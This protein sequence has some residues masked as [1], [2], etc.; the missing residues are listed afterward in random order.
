[1]RFEVSAMK[2]QNE[3]KTTKIGLIPGDWTVVQVGSLGNVRKG[4]GISRNSVQ[5]S[6][7]PC[8]RYG[9]IYT[10]YNY[11]VTKVKSYISDETAST[12]EPI[13]KGDL[14]FTGSGETA[15]DIGKAVVYLLDEP[16]Y[17]GGDLLILQP[18]NLIVDPLYLSYQW[19]TENIR[20]QRRKS[21]QGASI[22]HL[23]ADALI[24]IAVPLPPLPEQQ[25]I[26]DILS[27]VDENISETESL[28]EK[29]RFLKQ[30]M[31]QR[32][33]TQGIGHTEFKDTEVGRI[34]ME[35]EVRSTEELLIDAKGS[36]KIGP[37]G[38]QL[39]KEYLQDSGY[40]RV[41]GQENVFINDFKIGT[42]WLSQE[43]FDKLRS[44]EIHPGE[45]VISMMGTIGKCVVVPEKICPGIMDSHLIRL[46]PDKTKVDTIYLKYVIGESSTIQSQI[47]ALSVGGI[48]DGLSSG[49]IKRLR[50]PIPS[51][52][53]QR[54]IAVIL[55][56]ID[57][58]IET[59]LTK[60]TAL[61]RLKSGLM[62][63]L[64]TGKIRV[65]V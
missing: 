32:L 11:A 1:M 6:G 37:F 59:Y 47:K 63:Q 40:Y 4:K 38:S 26:A 58:Q 24:K 35:W 27:T 65:K 57:D 61:T 14:L 5:D 60:L 36:L 53:E 30:G 16:G 48:M 22:F 46:Q 31:I 20:S 33:L 13:S 15:E 56:T 12:S 55:T 50:F 8:V 9:E 19:E 54:Q 41:Y 42:R 21:G 44:C 49:V 52:P 2:V 39:K 51:L 17:A 25:K 64:L 28:I 45:I 10:D 34:P 18:D 3:Y 62:Q 29:T 23:Y 43:M 7:Y